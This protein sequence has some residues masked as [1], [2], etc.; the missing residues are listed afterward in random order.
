MAAKIASKS[1]EAVSLGKDLFYRQ[2]EEG[3][4]AAY[5]RAG[6]AITCNMQS[7]ATRAAIDSFLNKTSL[8][9]WPDRKN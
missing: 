2:L 8:A 1:P 6:E 5:D 7:D 4:E 9:K 3:M